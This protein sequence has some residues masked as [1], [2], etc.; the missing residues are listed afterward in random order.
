MLLKKN[1]RIKILFGAISIL[2]FVWTWTFA[3]IIAATPCLSRD[4]ERGEYEFACFLSFANPSYLIQNFSQI[5]LARKS[6]VIF[7]YSL[8]LAENH[9]LPESLEQMTR[10]FDRIGLNLRSIQNMSS[11]S[12]SPVHRGVLARAKRIDP[13]TPEYKVFTAAMTRTDLQGEER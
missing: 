8:V 4:R 11:D 5:S 1:T 9:R 2:L 3:G 7:E 6:L 10:L 13:A 12:L